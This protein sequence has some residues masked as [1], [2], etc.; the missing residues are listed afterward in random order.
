MS[1]T[2][3]RGETRQTSAAKWWWVVGACVVVPWFSQPPLAWW[4]FGLLAIT[5]Y[6][7]FVNAPSD[8]GRRQLGMLFLGAFLYWALTLQGLRH[9]HPVI[10]ACWLVLAAYLA[11]YPVLFVIATRRLLALGIPLILTA[12]VLWVAIECVRNYLLSGISAAM[13]GHTMADVPLMIQIAD[14]GGSYAVSLV[15]AAINVGIFEL[16]RFC[17]SR[18]ENASFPIASCATAAALTLVTLAYGYH[19]MGEATEEP[20]TTFGLIARDEP[21]EYFQ[22]DGREIAI[23]EAY[24]RQSISLTRE[25]LEPIDVIVWP[26]SMFT[27]TLPWM[28][29]DGDIEQ[30]R[31][32]G[33]SASELRRRLNEFR[34]SFRARSQFLQQQMRGPGREV[35]PDLLVGCGVID[36]GEETNVYSG[37]V[38]VNDRGAVEEWYAK[39]H[40]VMFGEY[41]PIVNWI[42]VVR[43]LIPDDIGL[44][45]GD[46]PTLMRVRGTTVLPN[47]CIETAV[48]RIAIHHLQELR[49]RSGI[50]EV[51][52]TV[53]NDGWF[54]DSSV[55]QHHKRCAQLVAVACR[56][57][58]LSAANNGPTCWIDS[59]GVLVKEVAQGR[60]G[61]LVA[62]PRID[63]RTPLTLTLGDWPARL[64]GLVFVA[65]LCWPR[66][67]SDE[68]KAPKSDATDA[69]GSQA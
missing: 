30:A 7:I 46:G 60:N 25:S 52:V 62:R 35:A 33:I 23:F 28:I 21:I 12:P 27:G 5:P 19:R 56:R 61:N 58:I 40:L 32:Y 55:V 49:D 22:E 48:E 66:R 2:E 47:I 59:R 11:T 18:S 67:K 41:I 44:T 4:P 45:D 31:E 15:V 3:S 26:E 24:A 17:I 50:P 29:G 8:L 37:L 39:N 43:D 69:S 9:A 1:D 13:L 68:T 54:D 34:S 42:P 14:L 65:T 6:L 36:Y 10:Y 51:I 63:S 53:S 16:L 57:P 20:Q 38:H 64:C